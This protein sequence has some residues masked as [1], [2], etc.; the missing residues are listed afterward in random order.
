MTSNSAD[1]ALQL[2]QELPC[3]LQQT[4]AFPIEPLQSQH[5]S[6]QLG[7]CSRGK[8]R[9]LAKRSVFTGGRT[10]RR[11]GEGEGRRAVGRLQRRLMLRR[12][13]MG[14]VGVL[15]RAACG[16]RGSGGQGDGYPFVC[17]KEMETKKAPVCLCQPHNKQKHAVATK[18]ANQNAHRSATFANEKKSLFRFFSPSFGRLE[19]AREVGCGKLGGPPF[20]FALHE[21]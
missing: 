11:H 13:G 6:R 18:S 8:G 19:Q 17:C 1:T 16:L 5:H 12:W 9:K 15:I 3:F 14:R 10:H 20:K 21:T 2:Q 4:D 7:E